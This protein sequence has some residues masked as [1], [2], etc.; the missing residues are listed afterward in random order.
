VRALL[1]DDL[2]ARADAEGRPPSFD[3][4]VSLVRE[5]RPVDGRQPSAGHPRASTRGVWHH[6]RM[7]RVAGP[8]LRLILPLLACCATML[9]CGASQPPLL[10]QQTIA[11]EVGRHYGDPNVAIVRAAPDTSDS[12]GSPIYLMKVAGRLRMGGLQADTLTFSASATRLYAWDIRAFDGAGQQVWL[13]PE[14]GACR[15]TCMTAMPTNSPSPK[16]T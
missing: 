11:R 8:A 5:H 3:M 15:S 13:E 1:A 6:C 7:L 16:A 4:A 12:D 9:A 2:R 14:W 10:S